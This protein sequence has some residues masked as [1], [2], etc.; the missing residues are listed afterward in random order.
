MPRIIDASWTMP[1]GPT[2]TTSYGQSSN[3][4]S[5]SGLGH[6]SHCV[7]RS[8]Q[9]RVAMQPGLVMPID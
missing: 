1:M 3:I 8:W 6:T 5:I 2:F 4:C 7:V 9:Q